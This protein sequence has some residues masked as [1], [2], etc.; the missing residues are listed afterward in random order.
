MHKVNVQDMSADRTLQIKWEKVA[1]QKII[2][3]FTTRNSKKNQNGSLIESETSYR[4][5]K[6]L[7]FHEILCGSLTSLHTSI[8]VFVEL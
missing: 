4:F 7:S 1:P 6:I 2:D 3:P 8:K 5:L